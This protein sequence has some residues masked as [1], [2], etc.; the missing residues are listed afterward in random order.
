MQLHIR[1][2]DKYVK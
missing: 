2:S 1:R